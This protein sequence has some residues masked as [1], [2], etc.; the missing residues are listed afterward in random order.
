V[1]VASR[2]VEAVLDT[3]K[4]V[5]AA[6]RGDLDALLALVSLDELADAWWRYTMRWDI[7]H[8]NGTTEPD[9]DTDPDAWASEIWHEEVLQQ[10]EQAVRDYL[11]V[12]AERAPAEADLG[13]MGAGPI[14]DFIRDD[15]HCLLWIEQEARRSAKF[16][17]ALANVW[18][19]GL[20]P[21]AFLRVQRAAGVELQWPDS[22]GLR[23]TD[24]AS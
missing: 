18:V 21:A 1:L 23:P 2:S 15:D 13:Y 24:Q 22:M 7:A 16:R 5:E 6:E 9:W 19:S 20:S 3:K 8:K 11:H 10:R 17:S 12:L 4:A 14:E